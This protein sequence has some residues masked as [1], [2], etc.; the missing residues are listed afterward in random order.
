MRSRNGSGVSAD[1]LILQRQ[2]WE[3]HDELI[4]GPPQAFID[5][6]EALSRGRRADGP[7]GAVLASLNAGAGG[8]HDELALAHQQRLRAKLVAS[9]ERHVCEHLERVLAPQELAAN[10]LFRRC[11]GRRNVLA[12]ASS[13]AVPPSDRA[14]LQ[15]LTRRLGA[16]ALPTSAEIF[17]TIGE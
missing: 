12:L 4:A 6:V 10:A 17:A 1:A 14:A 13:V 8:Q 15:S 11:A 9:L 7:I 5:V 3:R 2:A 16:L